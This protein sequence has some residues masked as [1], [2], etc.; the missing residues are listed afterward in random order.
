[1][2]TPA[3]QPMNDRGLRPVVIAPTYNNAGTLGE[4]LGGLFALDL[5][6]IIVND[7]STDDTAQILAQWN[8]RRQ[9]SQVVILTH[10]RNRGKAAALRTGFAAAAD[11][12]FTHAVTIDTD[13]QHD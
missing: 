4:I 7:G 6:V 10:A 1:M 5:P 9:A 2:V 3:K 13:S 8:E 11:S 12:G